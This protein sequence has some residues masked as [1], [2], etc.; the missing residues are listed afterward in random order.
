MLDGHLHVEGLGIPHPDPDR[1][2]SVHRPDVTRPE[3]SVADAMRAGNGDV[4]LE[5]IRHDADDGEIGRA[6][7]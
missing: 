4:A 5:N 7:V 3:I 2:K 6:H 1:F